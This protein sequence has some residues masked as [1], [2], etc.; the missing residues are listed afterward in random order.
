LTTQFYLYLISTI[1]WFVMMTILSSQRGEHTSKTSMKFSKKLNVLMKTDLNALNGN[2]RQAAHVVL[3]A[4]LT[5]LSSLTL[6]EADL[7]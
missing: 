3:F 5:V 2:L 4:I 6:N 1:V 7:R